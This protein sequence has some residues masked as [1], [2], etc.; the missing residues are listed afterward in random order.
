M[1]VS[2]R[3]IVQILVL[4]CFIPITLLC[5]IA[6]AKEQPTADYFDMSFE[7][8]LSSNVIS[9]SEETEQ[10]QLSTG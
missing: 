2:N 6:F 7:E 1:V 10:K 9:A 4:I 3:N 8:L 5:S